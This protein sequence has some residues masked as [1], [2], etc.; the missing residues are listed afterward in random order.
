MPYLGELFALLTAVCW[1]GSSYGF[2]DAAKR[3]GS[4]QL[5]V[6]RILLAGVFLIFIIFIFNF[7]FTISSH[8]AINLI[9]S[10]LIG[11]VFGDNYLFKAYQHI[12]ARLGMLLMSL[13]PIFSALLAYFFLG[14]ILTSLGIIGMAITIGGVAL[15]IIEKKEIP[16]SNYHISKIGIFYG[17][18]GALGQAVG[19]IFA[20]LAFNEGSINGFVATFVR[21]SSSGIVLLF[22]MLA[23]RRY[24][25]PIKLFTNDIKALFSMIIGTVLGPVFGITLSLLA[26]EYAKV[27]IAATLMSTMPILMLPISRFYFKENL[28][29]QAIWGAVLAVCGVAILFIR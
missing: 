17:I 6:N 24:K 12:G 1:S 4:L 19:L 20:K 25:N 3:I 14:E 28:N 7:K 26:I 27:G 11:L 5:N 16:D 23:A 18:L 8:Q 10:G 15:V 29:W 13:S 9:I 22:L 2:S 21:I